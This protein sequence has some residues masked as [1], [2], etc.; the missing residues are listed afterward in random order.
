MNATAMFD[1][2]LAAS[3]AWGSSPTS[4][5]FSLP[6]CKTNERRSRRIRRIVVDPLVVA[7][8]PRL[9]EE[10]VFL[11]ELWRA[12]RVRPCKALGRACPRHVHPFAVAPILARL[13]RCAGERP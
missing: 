9:S 8:G 13:G 7:G 6:G 11:V 12:W 2:R 4:S 3:G 5:S 1:Y 10:E